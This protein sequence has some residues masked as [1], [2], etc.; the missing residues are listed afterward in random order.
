MM[1]AIRIRSITSFKTSSMRNFPNALHR[2]LHSFEGKYF[3]TDEISSSCDSQFWEDFD[4]TNQVILQRLQFTRY[5]HCHWPQKVG[6]ENYIVFSTLSSC[7]INMDAA[8]EE[9]EEQV[10]LWERSFY[11]YLVLSYVLRNFKWENICLVKKLVKL[12]CY[13]RQLLNEL[14]L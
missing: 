4:Q 12:S 7:S 3:K 10:R 9:E 5:F 11:P 1:D 8:I 13:I 2:I 6:R 14:I